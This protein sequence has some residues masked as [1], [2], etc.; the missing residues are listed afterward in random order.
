MPNSAGSSGENRSKLITHVFSQHTLKVSQG[1][2]AIEHS[3][4]DIRNTTQNN[5]VGERNSHRVLLWIAGLYIST[6]LGINWPVRLKLR[7]LLLTHKQI[8]G[9][10]WTCVIF[11]PCT[12][13]SVAWPI[14]WHSNSFTHCSCCPPYC[15]TTE[16]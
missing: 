16:L 5:L 4:Y 2:P 12:Y 11:K 9:P 13:M 15:C 8:P 14:T 7:E 10:T 3:R 6:S 1:Q